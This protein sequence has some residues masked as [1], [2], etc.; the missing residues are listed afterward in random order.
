MPANPGVLDADENNP[1]VENVDPLALDGE[2][3]EKDGNLSEASP[4]QDPG[5]VCVCVHFP[6]T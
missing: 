6:E 3:T 4:G 5:C 2:P 1:N